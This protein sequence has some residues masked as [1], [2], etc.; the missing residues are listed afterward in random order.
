MHMGVH[1]RQDCAGASL[2]VSRPGHVK[3]PAQLPTRTGLYPYICPHTLMPSS[4]CLLCPQCPPQARHPCAVHQLNPW[5]NQPS[6][7]SPPFPQAPY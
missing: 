3:A 6:A 1:A 7:T 4:S 2:N 5:T